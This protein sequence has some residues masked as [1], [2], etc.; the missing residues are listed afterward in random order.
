M[1]LVIAKNDDIRE[2]N[3]NAHSNILNELDISWISVI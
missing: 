1:T 2:I 3:Y